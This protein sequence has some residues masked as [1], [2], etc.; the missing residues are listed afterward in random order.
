MPAAVLLGV[1]AGIAT[2]RGGLP[3]AVCVHGRRPP[4]NRGRARMLAE[5]RSEEE[6]RR[7]LA[8]LYG[9]ENLPKGDRPRTSEVQPLLEDGALRQ[10]WGPLCL[11]DVR[12][13]EGPLEGVFRPTMEASDLIVARC[14]MP[15]G[16]LLEESAE[17]VVEVIELADEGGAQG[18][19]KPGDVLRGTTACVPSM[20]YSSTWQIMLGG[21]GKPAMLKQLL[22][23]T[24]KPLEMVM[25]AIASNAN[26]APPAQV[27][28]LAERAR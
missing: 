28:L 14:E 25:G 15:L 26:Q 17:G 1:M 5:G 3:T 9:Q 4:T 23:I 7:A 18:I 19:L 8:R 11:V 6:R 27:I 21:V 10:P 2:G 12:G 22:D 20:S 13:A 24:G 16:A